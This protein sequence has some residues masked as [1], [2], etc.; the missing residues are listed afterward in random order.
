[1]IMNSINC[2]AAGTGWAIDVLAKK[3]GQK[4]PKKRGRIIDPP[5][6]K[7]IPLLQQCFYFIIMAVEGDIGS[8]EML[9]IIDTD[10]E[11]VMTYE[12]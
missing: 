8:A 1:M 3:T 10:T 7:S 12:E 2:K 4:K 6:K 9:D 11:S 5:R